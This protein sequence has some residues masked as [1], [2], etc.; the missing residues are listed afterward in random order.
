MKIVYTRYLII[1]CKE[2]EKLTGSLNV[3]H[4][5]NYPVYKIIRNV[6]AFEWN[7]RWYKKLDNNYKH[8]W[9]IFLYV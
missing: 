8:C 9:L 5:H 2:F 6:L 7:I 4:P 3:E 1:K